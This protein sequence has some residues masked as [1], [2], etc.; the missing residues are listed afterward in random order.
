M[1]NKIVKIMGVVLTLATL[2]SLFVFAGPVSATAPDQ[3]WSTISLPGSSGLAL[4]DNITLTGPVIHATADTTGNTLFA[5][6]EQGTTWSIIRTT[7]FGR[8]WSVVASIPTAGGPVVAM[9]SSRSD[10]NVLYYAT[11]TTVYKSVNANAATASSVAW[12][13]QANIPAGQTIVS[14]DAVLYAGRYLVAVGTAGSPGNVYWMDE[15]IPFFSFGTLGTS[16]YATAIGGGVTKV[17][18]VYFS[19][20]FST[21]RAIFAVGV[22]G[23]NTVLAVNV[24]GGDWTGAMATATLSPATN[25]TSIAQIFFPTDYNYTTAPRFYIAFNGTDS[26]LYWWTGSAL[27][28]TF[29]MV[30]G[31][32]PGLTGTLFSLDGVGSFATASMMVGTSTGL[33]YTSVNGGAVWYAPTKA[34]T[35]APRPMIVIM[36]SDFATSHTA[37]AI[38]TGSAAN[39][40]SGVSI[41]QDSGVTFNQISLLNDPLNTPDNIWALALGTNYTFATGSHSTTSTGIPFSAGGYVTFTPNVY[42][43][44]S[45]KIT[46]SA[47]SADTITF[48]LLAGFP[49]SQ[50]ITVPGLGTDVNA[51]LGG[52]TTT[53]GNTFFLNTLGDTV[54][55]SAIHTGVL[56]SLTINGSGIPNDPFHFV[57]IVVSGGNYST[58]INSLNDTGT[59]NY[60]LNKSTHDTAT[61][62]QTVAGLTP[63]IVETGTVATTV[64]A[65]PNYVVTFGDAGDYVIFTANTDGVTGTWARTGLPFAA[66]VNDVNANASITAGPG[67]YS[68]PNGIAVYSQLTLSGAGLA[69][70][71]LTGSGYFNDTTT[72]PGSDIITFTSSSGSLMV[73]NN[74]TSG[75]ISVTINNT[76]VV[77][78]LPSIVVAGGRPAATLSAQ[79]GASGTYPGTVTLIAQINAVPSVTTYNNSVWRYELATGFWERVYYAVNQT[80]PLNLAQISTT[81]NALYIAAS[82]TNTVYKS[83]D[84]GQTWA[85]LLFTVPT[86]VYSILAIDPTTIIVGGVGNTYKSMFNGFWTASPVALGNITSLAVSSSNAAYI[87]AGGTTAQTAISSDT[88]TTWGSPSAAGSGFGSNPMTV[89]FEYGSTSA[90]YSIANSVAGVYRGT[91]RV[92]ILAGALDSNVAGAVVTAA[93]GLAV[94]AA[95]GTGNTVAYAQDS[96]DNYVSRI[97]NLA[98]ATTSYT[99]G[100]IAPATGSS[101]A[102]GLWVQAASGKNILWSIYASNSIREYIDY[103]AVTVAGVAAPAA[104]ITPTSAV[105]NWTAPATGTFA[106][107]GLT[108]QASIT[109]GATALRSPYTSAAA[110]TGSATTATLTGLTPNTQY[111]VTVWVVSPLVSFGGTTAG[112]SVTFTTQ[113]AAPVGIA[114]VAPANQTVPI[115]PSFSWTSVTGATGY[116]LWISQSD[117]TFATHTT[118]TVAVSGN[119]VSALNWTGTPLANNTTYYWEVRATAGT[120]VSPFSSIYGFT[121]VVAQLPAV[122]VTQST[123]TLTAT[124]NPVPTIIVNL[125]PVVTVTENAPA[126]T[127]I[128]TVTQPVYT[129][130]AAETTT[131]TYI[132]IIVGIGALLTLAVIILIIRTRRVV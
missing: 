23:T 114:P 80:M 8:S 124:S 40:E 94:G 132:W 52:T 2:V 55:L 97:T 57:S 113:L 112:V 53:I 72:T 28:S 131:P 47:N 46:A 127:P 123:T 106:S 49:K 29:V 67:A 89:A 11:A 96:G 76:N 86:N 62:T 77:S 5:F 87:V 110:Y 91:T 34:P 14:M 78:T 3:A 15:S 79:S 95:S 17:I 35:G 45:F 92:D 120:I 105:I 51:T 58:Q 22:N 32:M 70:A 129:I 44:D 104:T 54:T 7:N 66:I 73:Q 56:Q 100:G 90:V 27:A 41:T 99:A 109:T 71:T 98:N 121:T 93:S 24:A 117:P 81:G 116:E 115:V 128:L 82:G 33:V 36:K 26:G 43:A 122:T 88:G 107:S 30:P 85:P 103:L 39:D 13:P 37:L 9:V 64:S 63:T 84:N 118:L 4:P 50:Q 19:P 31:P 12:N 111:T 74:N 83:L 130:A 10:V 61:I 125:P 6:I 48:T 65:G 108:Y 38:A 102:R 126:P 69:S 60:T 21:D 59:V 18:A 1:K 16:D 119:P 42:P 68:L 101:G 75:P 25:T 20:N